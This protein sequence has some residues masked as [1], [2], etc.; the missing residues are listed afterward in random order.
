MKTLKEFMEQE[1]KESKQYKVFKFFADTDIIEEDVIKEF[2]NDNNLSEDDFKETVF[3][4]LHSFCNSGQWNRKERPD[5]DVDQLMKGIQ[6]EYEHT[7]NHLIAEKIALDHLSESENSGKNYYSFLKIMEK[8]IE[9][10]FP[11]K[12][13]ENFYEENK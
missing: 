9:E 3:D 10:K 1:K 11:L 7:D 8:M 6:V 5:V 13:L 12:K 4:V 2:L